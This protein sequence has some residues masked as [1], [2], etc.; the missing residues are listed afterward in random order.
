MEPKDIAHGTRVKTPDGSIGVV[1]AEC[2]YTGPAAKKGPYCVNFYDE[3]GDWVG[4]AHFAAED[5]EAAT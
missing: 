2:D 5:L 4:A 1:D 3:D